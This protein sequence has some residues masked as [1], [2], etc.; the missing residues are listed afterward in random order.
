MEADEK[1][2]E[3][4]STQADD[5]RR[6]SWNKTK[7]PDCRIRNDECLIFITFQVHFGPIEQRL[8]IEYRDNNQVALCSIK[9]HKIIIEMELKPVET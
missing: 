5:T 4:K 3:S 1:K 2:R 8:A 6:K 7:P 9:K